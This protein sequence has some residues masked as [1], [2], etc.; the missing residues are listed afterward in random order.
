MS[1][2][3]ILGGV[4]MAGFFRS[5]A[6]KKCVL[7]VIWGV[8]LFGVG[9]GI[10]FYRGVGKKYDKVQEIPIQEISVEGLADGTYTGEYTFETLYAKVQVIVK[11]GEIKKIVL[12]DFVTEKGEDAAGI[13]S[14]IVENQSVMVDDVSKATDSS[15]VIKLAVMDAL[16]Q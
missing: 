3:D 1:K 4:K 12:E 7:I 14:S 16:A 6:F 5:M 2:E 15:R 11:G 13:V 10:S 8:T 9:F